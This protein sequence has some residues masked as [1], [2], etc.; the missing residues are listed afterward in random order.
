MTAVEAY[1]GRVVAWMPPGTPGRDQIVLE[2]GDQIAERLRRGE[3]EADVLGHLG[4]P[5]ALAE[6]YLSA[7]PLT[8]ASFMSRVAAK[9]LDAVVFFLAA[10]V[11][12]CLAW[13]LAP[14]EEWAPILVFAALLLSSITFAVYTVLAESHSGQTIGKRMM[15]I[16]AVR[17]SGARISTGQ[18]VVRQLPMFFEVFAVDALFAL[19]TE[20]SQRAF[21]LLSKT[22]VIRS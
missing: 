10:A 22:R 5:L 7:V 4:D 1:L 12:A 13:F 21:E 18:A 11:L 20:R 16:R 6:S 3:R 15:G 9:L 17:E 14:A 8:A 19:V 2:L